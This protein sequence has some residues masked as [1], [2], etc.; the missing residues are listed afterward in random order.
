MGREGQ[1]DTG[2]D[3]G[4]LPPCGENVADFCSTSRCVSTSVIGN[5][6]VS[7]IKEKLAADRPIMAYVAVKV[8]PRG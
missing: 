8:R 6:S 3:A 4:Q 2:L 1:K 7:W 5:V